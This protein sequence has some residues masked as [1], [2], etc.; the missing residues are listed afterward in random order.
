MR[1]TTNVMNVD[2]I[3]G[4]IISPQD[5]QNYEIIKKNKTTKF[6]Y[7]EQKTIITITNECRRSRQL[8]IW[9]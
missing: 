8:K 9:E 6:N 5:L 7:D 4:E 3:T 2:I 1:F